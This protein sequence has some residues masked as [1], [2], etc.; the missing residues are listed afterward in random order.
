MFAFAVTCR[1]TWNQKNL[2]YEIETVII[3]VGQRWLLKTWNQKNLDYEIETTIAPKV[4]ET[5]DVFSWNQKNLDYEIET[6]LPQ[7]LPNRTLGLEIKR[8]SITRLKRVYIFT[9]RLW[10][11][12]WA[13]NQKNLDYEIETFPFCREIGKRC[14]WVEIKRTSITRLKLGR[15]LTGTWKI[16]T[17][18]QKNL[19][20]E[21]ETRVQPTGQYCDRSWNQ[22]NLDYEIETVCWR[23][24]QFTRVATWNQ[25]NLDY[26]IETYSRSI[27]SG[28]L[29]CSWNQKNLDY[30]IET[31]QPMILPTA[32][33]LEIKRTSITR[34]KP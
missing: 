5:A 23:L 32:F 28:L 33:W 10:V 18:N 1:G 6:D 24:P 27:P 20:Y 3:A 34:L 8:T 2:D 25:K 29:G 15:S 13:W 9:A 22:K 26:E 7:F 12:A 11:A 21:I 4:E 16:Y 17:W 31:W 30:E 19:D 14:L